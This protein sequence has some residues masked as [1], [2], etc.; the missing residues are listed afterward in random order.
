MPARQEQRAIVGLN[1]QHVGGLRRI[2]DRHE[3]VMDL[4]LARAEIVFGAQRRFV[5]ADLSFRSGIVHRARVPRPYASRRWVN[6]TRDDSPPWSGRT[7]PVRRSFGS[8]VSGMR[9]RDGPRNVSS[10][11]PII[12]FW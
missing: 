10:L 5:A 7:V 1:R 9:T 6:D 4:L 11:S 3:I 8:V 12:M 2:S